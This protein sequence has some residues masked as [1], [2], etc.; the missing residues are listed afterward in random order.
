MKSIVEEG[1]TITKAIEKAWSR[2]GKPKEFKVKIFE[3]AQT[4]MFGLTKKY[5]KI[6]F[7]FNE[8][9]LP[10]EREKKD[11]GKRQER[12]TRTPHQRRYKESQQQPAPAHRQAQKEGGARQS[13]WTN[14]LVTSAENWVKDCLRLIGLPN[15]SFSTEVSGNNLKLIFDV[16]VTGAKD[17]ERIFS[18]SLAYLIIET[19]QCKFKQ[20]MR[21]MKVFIQST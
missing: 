6:G 20:P 13:R 21:G 5:A 8:Q 17:Q 18:Y 16:S 9:L 19:L 11:S 10:Q 15:L 7:F 1:S 3:E 4:N 14:E 2:A 12:F